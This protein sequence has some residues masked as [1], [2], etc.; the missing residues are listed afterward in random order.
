DNPTTIPTHP[1][2]TTT[3][4][5]LHTHGITP[6]WHAILPEATR[7]DLPTY[8]FQRESYWATTP[9]ADSKGLTAAGLDAVGHPL[10]GAAVELVDGGDLVLSGR[11][12]LAAYPWLADHAIAGT[13]TLPGTAFVELALEAGRQT[14][15]GHLDELTLTQPLVLTEGASLQLQVTVRA[16][17]GSG[18]R[19]VTVGSRADSDKPWTRH[20]SGALTRAVLPEP[21]GE[22]VWPPAGAAPVDLGVLYEEELPERGYQ[23]GPAFQGLGRLWQRD[24][25]LFAE[26]TLSADEVAEADRF[27]LHPALLDAVL[28]AVVR[29]GALRLPFSWNGVALHATSA[30]TLRARITSVGADAVDLAVFDPAGQPVLSVR[31]LVLRTTTAQAL[32]VSRSSDEDQLFTVEWVPAPSAAASALPDDVTLVRMGADGDKSGPG[33]GVPS[34]VPVGVRSSVSDTLRMVREWLSDEDASGRLVVVTEGA[35]AVS[36]D[37][38][39]DLAVAPVWGLLRSAQSENPGRIVLV[40]LDRSAAAAT[41]LPGALAGGE[42]Q[43]ALRGNTVL[44]PR[45]TRAQRPVA[46]EPVLDTNGTV[47][48][49]GGTGTLGTLIVRHL[50]REHGVRRLLLTSRRGPG[51]PGAA[52]LVAELAELGAHADVVACDTGNRESVATVL[53][54]VS[55]EHPL[56]GVLHA[57]GVLDD[58]VVTA[59]TDERVASVLRPK[60]DGA[61]HLHELTRDLPDLRAFV[62]FSSVSAVIGNPGQAG[63]SAANTFLDALARRRVQEGLPAVSLAWGLWDQSA[64]MAGGLSDADRARMARN[65]VAPLSVHDGL[66]LL[67]RAFDA[68]SPVLVPTRLDLAA[69]RGRAA[70]GDLPPLF[71]SLV[72]GAALR[73]A[74][75]AASGPASDLAARLVGLSEETQ[76]AEVL[77]VVRGTTASVL[78]H[79]TADGLDGA[80]AFKELGFDSLMSVD[81]RNRLNQVTGLRLP[82]TLVFDHPTPDAVAALVRS[83]VAGDLPTGDVPSAVRAVGSDDP[84]AI[85]AMACRYPGDV[86]TPEDLWRLVTAGTDA[87]SGFPTDRGWDIAELY[88]PDPDHTGTSYSRH[89]GFLHDAADFDPDFFGISPREALTI[90]PQQRL[91]LQTAW[92]AFER[93]GLRPATLQGSRTGVFTGVMYDDYGARLRPA[94]DGFEG[95]IGNGSMPSVASGRVSYTFGLEGPAVSVDTACSSSLV[96]L[97][98]ASQALRSGECDLALAGG[99]TVMA[100]PAT[101]VDFSRQRGLSPDGRCKP[102]AAAADGTGWGEGAGLL[103][104]ER[105][106]DARRNGHPVLALVRG[107]AVN[108]DGASNGLTA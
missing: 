66:A 29:E 61:W 93:A 89:G 53:S 27:N 15:Y 28:H 1:D 33:D 103:L 2:L 68:D 7:V 71:S 72:H 16:D 99:V 55:A 41:A 81:L 80:R 64:G 63:Y 18:V 45:L 35:V 62:L 34:S 58:G 87:I 23:Y 54:A 22:P 51:A 44:V 19:A 79:V 98:L 77:D 47:L 67:D 36:D 78:G 48:V 4:A 104:L 65:G 46:A 12:S 90:D 30:T 49:T 108:Q 11:L 3:L 75:P 70:A 100:T 10:L 86:R 6:D 83:T 21:G 84:I 24:D 69:L 17:D 25:A 60:V 5:H 42:P 105:L 106:S 88:D 56:T 39:Q 38:R 76:L 85:V 101:F 91:L 9:G 37:E 57:A 96:A 43:L 40:D 107:S 73:V 14:G 31:R 50:V 97:H 92:E 20:A 95:Y 32:T 8:P 102:F 74:A 13:V 52:E 82:T 94:P 59:L 26:V